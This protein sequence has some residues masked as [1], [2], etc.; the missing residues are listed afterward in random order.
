MI[1]IMMPAGRYRYRYRY[2][3][4]CRPMVVLIGPAYRE[5]SAYQ[6]IL[7][8]NTHSTYLQLCNWPLSV[9]SHHCA[10]CYVAAWAKLHINT[11]PT[12]NGYEF[13]DQNIYPLV[14]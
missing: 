4:L 9:V 3:Y 13:C 11:N 10:S 5:L 1:E 2:R 7:V 6:Y 14:L 12:F 8:V